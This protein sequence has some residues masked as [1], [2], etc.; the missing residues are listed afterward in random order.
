MKARFGPKLAL[1]YERHVES[2]SCAGRRNDMLEK[3]WGLFCKVMERCGKAVGPEVAAEH[4]AAM[5][6]AGRPTGAVAGAAGGREECW[7][8]LAYG[9]CRFGGPPKCRL[10]HDGI[11]GSRS[12]AV[13]D[14]HGNCRQFLKHGDCRRRQRGQKCPHKHG[15]RKMDDALSSEQHAA[16]T[17]YAESNGKDAWNVSWETVAADGAEKWIAAGM[18]QLAAA[19]GSQ[20]PRVYPVLQQRARMS[21]SDR[22]G[23][24]SYSEAAA[25]AEGSEHSE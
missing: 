22:E 25:V 10:S 16:V 20:R 21:M 1:A 18:K 4:G 19:E 8:H 17:C 15:D 5:E 14:E 13:V 12:G 2:E 7:D 24:I 9:E 23:S 3:R 11:A 6:A